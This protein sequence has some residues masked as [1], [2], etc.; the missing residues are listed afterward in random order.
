MK[1]LIALCLAGILTLSLAACGNTG[2]GENTS[3]AVSSSEA[4]SSAPPMDEA[5]S[6]SESVEDLDTLGNIDVEENLFD[7]VITIP[8]DMVE[9]SSPE[10]VTQAA[11]EAGVHSATLNED[12][13]VT[14]TM[15]KAQ[16]Q[17]LLEEI[18]ASIQQSLNEMVGSEDYPN[19]TAIEANDN[20]TE[21]TVTTSSSELSLSE[22][23][24]VMA[25]YMYGGI[26]GIF[27]GETPDNIHV[28]FVN[29]ET[30]EIMNSADSSD[31]QA[32]ENAE[33]Q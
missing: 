26:Y 24:S 16:H 4:S 33:S 25:Y 27:S 5:A 3:T 18:R 29:A 32:S 9:S 19:I 14:Y 12:G 22:S 7:V 23:F 30:G 8:A 2:S 15:S 31:M 1:K 13:S 20:F 21:F 6:S 28:D 10:E 11:E 17:K